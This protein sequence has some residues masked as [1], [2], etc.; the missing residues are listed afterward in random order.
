MGA[1]DLVFQPIPTTSHA[2]RMKLTITRKNLQEAMTSA[3]AT[4]PT[5]TT[6]PVLSNVLIQGED[7]TVAISGTDLDVSIRVKVSADVIEPGSITVP[8][9]TLQDLIRELPDEPVDLRL[10]GTQLEILCGRSRFLLLGLPAEE[11]PELPDVDFASGWRVSE[12]VLRILIR[13]TSFAAS[14]QD[15]R[16]ILNGVFWRVKEG[17][18]TM[19]AT[20]GH[21]LA[22]MEATIGTDPEA[23]SVQ[24]IVP[25]AALAQVTRLFDGAAQV[26][27]AR[28]GNHLAF[29]SGYKEVYTRLIDGTYPNYDQV[30]P[31][32]NDKIAR[33]D[34]DALEAAARRMATVAS[35]KTYRMK[36]KF[37]DDR[38]EF[39][40]V[41]PDRG[42]AYDDL[43]IDYE[44]E[45]MAIG[46]SVRYLL[47]V[48]RHMPD[49]DIKFSFKTDEKAIILEPID[50]EWE[51]RYICLLMPLRLN[52]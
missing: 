21:R 49:G 43:G 15:A 10:D 16:P 47:E 52:D 24:L 27:V 30:I 5:K 11:F 41:T 13:G 33:I 19:V 2:D 46:L 23:E 22:K 28:K 51:D 17:K 40:V 4:I 14:T 26:M 25:P 36:V 18:M 35:D 42:E 20:N 9:R 32:D 38:M 37:K 6:L 44:G 48:L 45:P 1:H 34:K 12:E 7:D 50:S 31:R 29:R 3:A 8:G 39:E